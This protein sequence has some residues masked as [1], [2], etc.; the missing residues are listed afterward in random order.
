MQWQHTIVWSC[1]FGGH[2]NIVKDSREELEDHLRSTHGDSLSKDQLR[3]L[4]QTGAR[5]HPDTF[6]VLAFDS[7]RAPQNDATNR[8]LVCGEDFA[9][10]NSTR[11]GGIQDHYLE[12]LEALALL[13]L[14]EREDADD[15]KGSDWREDLINSVADSKGATDTLERY[16]SSLEHAT[17]DRDEKGIEN[18][19][20]PRG[21]SSNP[22]WAGETK[23]KDRAGDTKV[24][25]GDRIIVSIDFGTTFSS[26]AWALT[27]RVSS[28]TPAVNETA[29]LPFYTAWSDKY[30]RRVAIC[31]RGPF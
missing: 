17:S 12:H 19:Q 2:E 22:A 31:H 11:T 9:D 7:L 10:Q 26:L 6:G 27:S 30:S 23:P 8:C 18:E 21:S 15:L 20:H 29:H 13:A 5:P 1:L 24:G 3:T 16:L 25:K 28:T 14:P 4:V